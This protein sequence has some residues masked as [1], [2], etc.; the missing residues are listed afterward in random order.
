MMFKCIG[1]DD[2]VRRLE[3][4]CLRD[5]TMMFKCREQDDLVRRLVGV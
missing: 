5:D 4:M 3:R 1:Q 2:L